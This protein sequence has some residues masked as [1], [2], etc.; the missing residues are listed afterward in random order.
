MGSTKH[1]LQIERA[2]LVERMRRIIDGAEAAG[3][4]M[5]DDEVRRF[6]QADDRVCAI[7]EELGASP[8]RSDRRRGR[9]AERESDLAVVDDP[10][11]RHGGEAVSTGAFDPVGRVTTTGGRGSGPTF[12]LSDGT[13]VRGLT[14]GERF[15][16]VAIPPATPKDARGLTAG[17]PGGEH[18]L[19]RAIQALVTGDSSR[20]GMAARD[21]VL[22]VGSS[23]G[24]TVTPDESGLVIDQARANSVLVQSGAVTLPLET[25]QTTVLTV[26][27]DPSAGWQGGELETLPDASMTFG[28]I[29]LVPATLGAKMTLSQQLV[30][31]ASN[32]PQLIEQTMANAIATEID[33]RFLRGDLS[34]GDSG[35]LDDPNVNRI[36]KGRSAIGYDDVLQG[37]RDVATNDGMANA[38]IAH[39][40]DQY[41]L[42]TAKDANNQYLTPPAGYRE[43]SRTVS[44]QIP[45]DGDF[46]G[47]SN[48]DESRAL[49]GNLQSGFVLFGVRNEFRVEADRSTKFEELGIVL[50]VW[51]R[52]AF[53]VGRPNHLTVI[54]E[55]IA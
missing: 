8:P 20:E 1:D 25:Q 10:A 39:P 19:G 42:D 27:S 3:R 9:T 29:L 55:L 23:G 49:V 26:D 36:K 14:A 28:R 22:E 37:K 4:D 54:D 16:D 53:A 24:F 32:A 38:F 51:G 34:G 47:G 40:R 45:T 13:T 46:S 2:E 11:P 52:A 50:R 30:E 12:T 35:L 48:G 15:R 6:D 33:R 31:D 5:T 21:Q 7:E 18:R 44:T 41:N 17:G 43:L